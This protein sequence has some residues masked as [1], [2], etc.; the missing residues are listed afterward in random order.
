MAGM[1]TRGRRDHAPVAPDA[2]DL[3]FPAGAMIVAAAAIALSLAMGVP[4][5]SEVAMLVAP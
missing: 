5:V 2:L 3:T 4:V 1:E